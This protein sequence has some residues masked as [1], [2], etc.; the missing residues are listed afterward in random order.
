LIIL[1]ILGEEYKLW[2]RSF[3]SFVYSPL[4]QRIVLQKHKCFIFISSHSSV[5]ISVEVSPS[6]HWF[7]WFR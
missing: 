2:S 5:R 1:M 6:C 7:S 3:C 4:K